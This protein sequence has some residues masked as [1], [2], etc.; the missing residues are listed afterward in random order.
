MS[1]VVD[2]ALQ[3]VCP[4]LSAH[5]TPPPRL[6]GTSRPSLPPFLSSR[7]RREPWFSCCLC[8]RPCS[9]RS[10]CPIAAVHHLA[11]IMPC[12]IGLLNLTITTP[13]R[14]ITATRT[15]C[16]CGADIC[17]VPV[18]VAAAYR[19]GEASSAPSLMHEAAGDGWMC[20][21]SLR[22]LPQ[23]YCTLARRVHA[24]YCFQA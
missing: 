21:E 9:C 22:K 12:D 2:L 6:R 15:R 10:P 20:L 19:C 11:S 24:L 3:I 8:F 14:D 23:D 16:L 18:L 17:P 7:L 1:L 5:A 13:V 4:K